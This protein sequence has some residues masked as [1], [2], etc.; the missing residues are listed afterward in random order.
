MKTKSN[1]RAVLESDIPGGVDFMGWKQI[2][3]KQYDQSEWGTSMQLNVCNP[4]PRHLALI[5]CRAI[6]IIYYSEISDA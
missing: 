5:V 3:E 1:L 2:F 6:S 4:Q